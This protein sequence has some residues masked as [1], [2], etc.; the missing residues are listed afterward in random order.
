MW[1]QVG[2]ST[3]QPHFRC[4]QKVRSLC[5]ADKHYLLTGIVCATDR[6][7]GAESILDFG[8]ASAL[9]AKVIG[10]AR[11][12]EVEFVV[13]TTHESTDRLTS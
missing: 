2:C 10:Q 8:C 13:G 5:A 4:L 7:V 9:D 1:R 11:V 6:N 3:G 12:G